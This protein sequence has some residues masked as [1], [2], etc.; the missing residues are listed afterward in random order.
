M[1]NSWH[2]GV[3][4]HAHEHT[5]A[6]QSS[7]NQ[8]S[9]SITTTCMFCFNSDFNQKTEWDRE[10][11][12]SVAR[13]TCREVLGWGLSWR[14]FLCGSVRFLSRF[15]GLKGKAGGVWSLVWFR[16]W[17]LP[18][19]LGLGLKGQVRSDVYITSVTCIN[20]CLV[21]SFGIHHQR[22]HTNP[23]H[24]PRTFFTS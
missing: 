8:A 16:F 9:T 11:S 7:K 10:W 20:P 19:L 17:F 1:V 24:L 2:V 5:N 4:A 6:C 14:S 12:W 18:A 15:L 23:S 22:P 3:S 21:K 13:V